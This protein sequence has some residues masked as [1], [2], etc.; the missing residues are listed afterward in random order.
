MEDEYKS[1]YVQFSVLELLN[2]KINGVAG[3]IYF[4]VK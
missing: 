1:R 3:V 4:Q 2:G